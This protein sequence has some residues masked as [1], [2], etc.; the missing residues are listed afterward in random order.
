MV[1]YFY[2][3]LKKYIFVPLII[4]TMTSK[5]SPGF[6]SNAEIKPGVRL[7]SSLSSILSGLAK[8]TLIFLLT[9]PFIEVKATHVVG[10]EITYSFLSSTAT[11]NTYR[12]QLTLYR[13]CAGVN[14]GNT[15][16]VNVRYPNNTLFQNLTLTLQG[17]AIDRSIVCAGQQSRCTSPSSSIPGVQEFKYAGNITVPKTLNQPLTIAHGICCR[18]NGITNLSNPGSQETYLSTV[19]PAQ[20]ANLDNSSPVFLNPP[21]GVFCQG[22]L[23]SLSLN[24]FDPDGDA[25]VYSLVAARRGTTT[26]TNVTYASGFSATTPMSSSTPVIINPATGV[27]NFTPSVINQRSVVAV[28]VEEYRNGTKIGE[29]YRDLEVT[30]INCGSNTAPAIAPINNQVV[31]VGQSI[32][33]PISVTD[34]NANNIAVT[35]TGG[36]VPPA[37]FTITSSGPGFT[38]GE[39]CFTPTLANAANTYAISISAVD[40]FCPIPAGVV[41]TFNVTVP[42]PQAIP[43]QTASTPAS[44]GL[45]DGSATAAM[46]G[47]VPPFAYSWTGPNG[48]TGSSQT[49]TGVPAGTY[50]ITVVDGN[51]CTGSS[52]VIVEGSATPIVVNGTVSNA[53]CGQNN[54]SLNLSASGGVA[55]YTYSLNGGISQNDGQFANLAPDTYT[56]TVLDANSCPAN[57][58]YVINA[59]ADTTPPTAICQNVTLYLDANG[60]ANIYP[61]DV[62][63]GSYDDCNSITLALSAMSFDCTNLGTNTVTLTVTD[64][65]DNV[66]TCTSIVTVLDTIAPYLHCENTTLYLNE[67]GQVSLSLNSVLHHDHEACPITNTWLSQ[68]LFS[69]ANLGEN[70]VTV[71]ASDNSNNI[72][73]CTSTVTIIDFIAPEFDIA[74]LQDVNVECSASV[75]APTATDNC[76]GS[77]TATTNNPTSY[78]AQGTYTITWTYDDGNGNT[79][80]QTQNVVVADV[81][82]PVADVAN[83]PTVT[84]ECSASVSAPTATDNCAGSLTATTNDPTSYSAQGTYTITWTYDDGNGNTY[85]QTQTVVVADVTAPVADLANLPTVTGECSASVSAPTATDNC[86]GSLTATTND[87]TSYSAQGTYTI[88]WTYDDG[89]GNT[90]AQTQNVVVADVTA[91]VAECKDFTLN[92]NNGTGIVNPSDVNNNSY[93]NCGIVSM[94]VSPNT[95]SCSD[96][97]VNTITLTVTD[98]NGNSS[99]CSANVTVK[100]QPSCSIVSVP[101]NNVYTG[102]NPNNIYLGYGPQSATLNGSANGGNGLTY[103]WSPATNLSCTNCANPVF[104]PT[105]AGTTTYTLTVTN[106]NGCSTTCE[107]TMCVIDARASGKGN[108]GKVLICHGSP[109]NPHT[110]SISPNAV[111]SHLTQ[112][113]G[114]QLGACGNSCGESRGLAEEEGQLMINEGFETIVYPNPTSNHFTIVINSESQEAVTAGMYDIMGKKIMD[115][116]DI[117]AN[118]PYTVHQSLPRG[119]YLIHIVQNGHQQTIRLIRQD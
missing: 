35:V 11:T 63:N 78:N 75:S 2:C 112:H 21:N 41:A 27:I 5:P 53:L 7:S 96:V 44:C 26:P 10:G 76:A 1:I 111:N 89:N 20:T 73:T 87:P 106:D 103:S 36:I 84:G 119:I 88:T 55:P 43:L 37:T 51:N 114:D 104:T 105:A 110:L 58:S 13:D 50:N 22:Q 65:N 30:T 24:A 77:I 85:A 98:V 34:A 9:L 61:A 12:I 48:F 100:E 62:N 60:N 109:N 54:G 3:L 52:E 33:I 70:T 31:Q 4:I 49:I 29:V 95:F 16:Q 67:T 83:L 115:L 90:S 57:V 15:A 18:A 72:G 108:N 19:L 79:S 8:L 107:I 68:S 42:C 32:C 46:S 116:K 69:C 66:S 101:A 118:E 91:P 40:N 86:A 82:A 64:A 80:T 102:G 47:G 93:D 23:A 56:I 17:T 94:S 14:L 81:T 117:H 28:R 71:F 39:F 99:T 59:A 45:A 92:L 97:G 113:S 25:L 38:N 6:I 74:N